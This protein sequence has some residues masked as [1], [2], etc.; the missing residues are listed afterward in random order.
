M[1]RGIIILWITSFIIF[2][3]LVFRH[4]YRFQLIY[5]HSILGYETPKE[6]SHVNPEE[7]DRRVRIGQREMLKS[8][9]VIC[10]LLRD[11]EGRIPGIIERVNKLTPY[12]KDYRVL[13]VENDSTDNTRKELLKW[14]SEDPKV[15]ILGCDRINVDECNLNLKKTEGHSVDWNRINKMQYIRNI[16]LEKIYSSYSNWDYMMVW[17]MDILGSIYIDGISNSFGYFGSKSYTKSVGGIDAICANGIFRWS[18][19][20]IY[21]DTYA[22]QDI[23]EKSPHIS[24]KLLNDI[25]KGIT[26]RYKRG[27]PPIRVKSCFGGFAIYK[28]K[29]IIENKAVYGTSEKDSGNI[30]CEHIIFNKRLKNIFINPSMLYIILKNG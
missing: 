29:S 5:N 13:I 10:G 22:H 8:R 25:N 24:D 23:T 26:V 16:Y 6:F 20:P 15:M 3:Y 19:I 12:Y 1:E 30:E 17:D 11:S 28:I 2:I 18:Y 14:A 27:E 9:V 4:Y 7:I 21:Y